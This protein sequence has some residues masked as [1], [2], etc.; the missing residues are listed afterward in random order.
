MCSSGVVKQ[1]KLYFVFHHIPNVHEIA[2]S[3]FSAKSA[4]DLP[5]V[6]VG[7]P[8]TDYKHCINQYIV[9]TFQGDWNGKVRNKALF[10]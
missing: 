9:S 1:N 8:Y 6:K 7:V 3:D 10:C 2:G 4:L 5:P